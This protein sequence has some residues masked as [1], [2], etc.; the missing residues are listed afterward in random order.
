MSERFRRIFATPRPV[1]AM[2][3]VPALPGSPLYD[4]GAG[5]QGAI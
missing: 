5:V 2:A 4:A 3:H 1:I